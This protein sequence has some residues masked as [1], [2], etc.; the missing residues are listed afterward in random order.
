L[1]YLAN[2]RNHNNYDNKI[3]LKSEDY[4]DN[5]N[6]YD[7]NFDFEDDRTQTYQRKQN[8]KKLMK[9]I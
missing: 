4:S 5:S 9:N 1:N 6:N 3:F 2:S 7:V 8:N